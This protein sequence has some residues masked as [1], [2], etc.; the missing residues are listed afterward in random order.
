MLPTLSLIS[1]L[2][3]YLF[4]TFQTLLYCYVVYFFTV[5]FQSEHPRGLMISSYIDLH[6]YIHIHISE[7]LFIGIFEKVTVLENKAEMYSYCKKYSRK[8]G[9]MLGISI[10]SWVAL[11]YCNFCEISVT[12]VPLCLKILNK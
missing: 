1:P 10:L 11:N 6:T 5:S 12:E 4:Y 2:P 9:G 8:H 7:Y 3:C